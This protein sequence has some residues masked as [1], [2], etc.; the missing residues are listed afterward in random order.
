MSAFVRS[1]LL[2]DPSLIG[3]FKDYRSGRDWLP[4]TVYL[5]QFAESSEFY[6]CDYEEDLN[7][8]TGTRAV[9]SIVASSF[10]RITSYNVCYTKLLRTPFDLPFPPVSTRDGHLTVELK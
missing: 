4:E 6:V 7:L 9:D 5:N 2:D 8:H 3:L 1:T 10:T